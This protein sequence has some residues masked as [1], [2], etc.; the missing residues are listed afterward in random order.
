M[1]EYRQKE[2]KKIAELWNEII[3]LNAVPLQPTR[4]AEDLMQP[5]ANL[6]LIENDSEE[7]YYGFAVRK[8]KIPPKTMER[9]QISQMVTPFATTLKFGLHPR[10]E[11]P[12]KSILSRT[13]HFV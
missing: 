1:H 9:V 11:K 2:M 8:T 12:R 5:S 10:V 7:K 13:D 3:N 4:Q 6:K